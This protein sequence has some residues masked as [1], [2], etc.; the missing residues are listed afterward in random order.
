MAAHPSAI[1]RPVL[2]REGR[3]TIGFSP[4]AYAAALAGL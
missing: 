3:L 2:D 1:R 4:E